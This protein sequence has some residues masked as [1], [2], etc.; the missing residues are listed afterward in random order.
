[1]ANSSVKQAGANQIGRAAAAEAGGTIK[2]S[3][4]GDLV[5]PF[6]ATP[7]LG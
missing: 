2:T 6:S 4:Q 5:K 3:A 1:M 7:S